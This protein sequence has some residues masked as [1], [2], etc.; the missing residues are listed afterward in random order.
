MWPIHMIQFI[1][2]PAQKTQVGE[3]ALIFDTGLVS[4]TDTDS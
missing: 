3:A 4:A 2:N 1:V